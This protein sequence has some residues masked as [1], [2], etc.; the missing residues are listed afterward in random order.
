MAGWLAGWLA[1]T[2]GVLGGWVV[3]VSGVDL[4]GAPFD[5]RLSPSGLADHGYYSQLQARSSSLF[6]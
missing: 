4:W 1:L 2:W 6:D 5:W 3:T